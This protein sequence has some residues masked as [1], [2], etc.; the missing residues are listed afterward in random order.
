MSRSVRVKVDFG[1]FRNSEDQREA[2]TAVVSVREE[3]N[4][5][6]SFQGTGVAILAP[7]DRPQ[8]ADVEI[9]RESAKV[10]ARIA[11]ERALDESRMPFLYADAVRKVA[12]EGL[13]K[14][15]GREIGQTYF[16][17]SKR[18]ELKPPTLADL[19]FALIGD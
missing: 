6:A 8:G 9:I 1:G 12:E 10:G 13:E 5:R 14:G 4:G 3:K 17:V 7:S 2:T 18:V 19:I 15:L 11:L 16:R